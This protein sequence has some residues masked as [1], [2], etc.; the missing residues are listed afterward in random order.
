MSFI[1]IT[2]N[3]FLIFLLINT[4]VKFDMTFKIPFQLLITIFFIR[5]FMLYSTLKSPL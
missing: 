5:I 3:L 1:N 2:P 4:K